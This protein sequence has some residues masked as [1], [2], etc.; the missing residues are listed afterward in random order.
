[1]WEIV[2]VY[3]VCGIF[4][5]FFLEDY[6][7]LTCVFWPVILAKGLWRGLKKALES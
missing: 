7:A 5:Y 2:S 6:E 4:T 1:M 3:V